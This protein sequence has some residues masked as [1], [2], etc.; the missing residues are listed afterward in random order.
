MSIDTKSL[1]LE[2]YSQFFLRMLSILGEEKYSQ[3]VYW[4]FEDISIDDLSLQF[5][6][7]QNDVLLKKSF[8]KYALLHINKKKN[9]LIIEGFLNLIQIFEYLERYEDCIILKDIKDSILIDL[10]P[11]V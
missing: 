7:V 5:Y 8:I 3:L 1:T 11:V 9:Y 4:P 6:K 2:E 10:K